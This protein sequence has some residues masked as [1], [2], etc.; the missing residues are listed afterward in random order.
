MSGLPLDDPLRELPGGTLQDI[1]DSCPTWGFKPHSHLGLEIGAAFHRGKP[2]EVGEAVPGCACPTCTEL[3]ADHAAR[4]TKQRATDG[5]RRRR[6]GE[7]VDAAR[8]IPLVDVVRRLGLGDPVNQGKRLVLRCPLHEDHRPSMSLDPD[9]GLWYCFP[10]AEGGDG[11]R[12]WMRTRR[13]D[14]T[15]AVQELTRSVE[16]A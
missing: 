15:A 7:S 13:V 11:I 12:L 5:D 4:R 3:P 6:W 1:M 16:A 8:D 10:C 2:L 14:F 9:K